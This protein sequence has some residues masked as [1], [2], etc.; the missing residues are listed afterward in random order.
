MCEHRDRAEEK[1]E[2]IRD[3]DRNRRQKKNNKHHT[4]SL[5]G[6][7]DPVLGSSRMKSF[8]FFFFSKSPE[9]ARRRKTRQ[10]T[11]MLYPHDGIPSGG[12][13]IAGTSRSRV[14]THPPVRSPV[15]SPARVFV[16]ELN[17]VT[18]YAYIHPIDPMWVN[19]KVLK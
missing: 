6:C 11:R 18:D 2:I 4:M 12:D 13:I 1:R 5:V 14:C 8:L 16:L 15:S 9:V 10:R 17:H 7:T 3:D 19:C